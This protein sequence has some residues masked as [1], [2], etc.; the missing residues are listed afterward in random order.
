[1]PW[2][3][4]GRENHP[5]LDEIMETLDEI[6]EVLVLIASELKVAPPTQIVLTPGTP[7]DNTGESNG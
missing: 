1:V 4:R 3:R 6:L 7:V 5:D 2:K